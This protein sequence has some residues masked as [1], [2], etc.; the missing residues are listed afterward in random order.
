MAIRTK[1]RRRITVDGKEYIW[2]VM[3]EKEGGWHILHIC[4]HD[5]DMRIR[6]PLSP[7]KSYG[8]IE[9]PFCFVSFNDDKKSQGD[10]LLPF[11][12]P[13]AVTP[14]VVK[15]IINGLRDN[16]FERTSYSELK[17]LNHDLWLFDMLF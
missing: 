4:D 11:E 13:A 15:A 16:T 8:K 7:D 2:Y 17:A 1:N 14:S 9:R 3:P 10:F 6:A 5:K 12:V